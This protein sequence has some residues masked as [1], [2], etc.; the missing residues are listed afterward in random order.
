MAAMGLAMEYALQVTAIPQLSVEQ[1]IALWDE[2][3]LLPGNRPVGPTDWGG[4]ARQFERCNQQL[5][6]AVLD[7]V[8]CVACNEPAPLR[9]LEPGCGI[10]RIGVSLAVEGDGRYVI[11]ALDWSRMMRQRARH[12]ALARGVDDNY[13]VKAGNVLRMLRPSGSVH[14]QTYQVAIA[15]AL[16]CHFPDHREFRTALRQ[17][18]GSLSIGGVL[19]IADPL[20]EYNPAY[21]TDLTDGL[22]AHGNTRIRGLVEYTEICAGSGMTLI[23]RRRV[24]YCDEEVYTIMWF[25]RK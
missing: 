16:L 15:V 21:R 24:E 12:A 3:A 2:K 7:T 20:L 14:P 17:L 18:I 8:H 13:T 10:G 23:G 25:R 11:D 22:K 6:T 1:R 4:E 19:V 9:V 5:A